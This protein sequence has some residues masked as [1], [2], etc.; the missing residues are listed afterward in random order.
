M[1]TSNLTM[2]LTNHRLLWY[3]LARFTSSIGN[4]L[5]TVATAWLLLQLSGAA[6]SIGWSLAVTSIP[7]IFCS[8]WI[9]VLVDRYDR[10]WICIG[11]DVF[12]G[13]MIAILPVLAFLH[14]LYI[15]AIYLVI[16][17]VAIGDRFYWPASTA[18][19]KEM[20]PKEDLLAAN[21]LIGMALQTGTL[22][23]ASAGGLLIASFG[24]VNTMLF[25]AASFIISAFFTCLIQNSSFSQT[26]KRES[27][28][29]FRE[30]LGGVKYLQGHAFVVRVAWLQSL[31][32]LAFYI[33][34]VLLPV[35]SVRVL[36]VGS[37]GYGLIDGGWAVGAIVGTILLLLA[38]KN[39][40]TYRFV[41]FGMLQLGLSIIVFLTARGL[42]QG[43]IGSALLGSSFVCTRIQFDTILQT[44]IPTEYQGRVQSTILMLT[45]YVSLSIYIFTGYLGD[46]V[47]LRLI[48]LALSLII[49][50]AALQSF[51]IFRAQR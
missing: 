36:K 27:T 33:I 23:G 50:F 1:T 43:I 32:F 12:R 20:L 26:L 38:L 2:P 48:F 4:G 49:F 11:A 13:C 9:G 45:A 25:N 5:Q 31:L 10:R 14:L 8:P 34:T 30:F 17:L 22:I 28:S 44:I 41:S 39:I 24:S 40:N 51:F 3:L 16:L 6:A 21:T 37:A 29:F 18:M 7:G 15:W 19:A 42:L 47:P 46:T 35:F